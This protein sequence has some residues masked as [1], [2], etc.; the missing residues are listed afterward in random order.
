MRIC[1]TKHKETKT[2]FLQILFRKSCHTRVW[3]QFAGWKVKSRKQEQ[4]R[5]VNSDLETIKGLYLDGYRPKRV[6]FN[7]SPW[8][9]HWNKGFWLFQEVRLGSL[10]FW[11]GLF[12]KSIFATCFEPSEHSWLFSINN[13]ICC[14]S[15]D[16]GLCPQPPN[17]S[18]YFFLS[19]KWA[20]V[21]HSALISW[22]I[23][24]IRQSGLSCCC[25]CCRMWHL[26]VASDRLCCAACNYA[27]FNQSAGAPEI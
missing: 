12:P 22:L 17:I 21:W 5:T 16:V 24:T 27:P 20:S 11:V 3:V 1:S 9:S 4:W 14:T 18:R 19:W 8:D 7:F 25:C 23:A 26:L 6:G 13:K 10:V 2:V 15:Q